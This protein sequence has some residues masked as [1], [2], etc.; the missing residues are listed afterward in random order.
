MSF[1]QRKILIKT[2]SYDYLAN[3]AGWRSVIKT[4][5]PC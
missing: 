5:R 4:A 1:M 3:G 2:N